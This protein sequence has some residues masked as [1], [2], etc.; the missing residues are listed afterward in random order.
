[1]TSGNPYDEY[2][3]VG[4]NM[5]TYVNL[6]FAQLTVFLALNAGLFTAYFS[7]HAAAYPLSTPLLAIVG[8]MAAVVFAVMESRSTAY[9]HA[10][11]DRAIE[12]LANTNN[13]PNAPG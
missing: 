1:M 8:M 11:K 10:L 2:T 9:Y 12:S 6:R 5:R 3:E 7:E 13:C 4:A